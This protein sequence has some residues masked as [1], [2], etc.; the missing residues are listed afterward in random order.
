M[1]VNACAN[2]WMWMWLQMCLR[3]FMFPTTTTTTI[4]TCVHTSFSFLFFFCIFERGA[5]LTRTVRFDA[6]GFQCY[7]PP[8][9]APPVF[10]VSK[11]KPAEN[12]Y[13][14]WRSFRFVSQHQ[15]ELMMVDSAAGRGGQRGK[16]WRRRRARKLG[17]QEYE[18][19]KVSE[20]GL[21]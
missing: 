5:T 13:R 19:E 15:L 18:P 10:A 9:A 16:E 2:V 12:R 7:E 17:G 3:P 4:H 11:V 14:D 21:M 20:T 6:I 8:K 1:Y